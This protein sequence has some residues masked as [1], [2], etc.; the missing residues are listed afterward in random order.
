MKKSII[1]LFSI[2]V[3]VI[4]CSALA[5][6]ISAKNNQKYSETSSYAMMVSDLNNMVL[7]DDAL[8]CSYTK[9]NSLFV[10]NTRGLFEPSYIELH[11]VYTTNNTKVTC[12]IRYLEDYSEKEACQNV[13]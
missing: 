12:A 4:Y 1:G 8:A 11:N 7:V 9:T 6:N 3:C 2:L 13:F 5:I 10:G